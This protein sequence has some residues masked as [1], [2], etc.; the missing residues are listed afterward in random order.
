M[1]ILTYCGQITL[2]KIDENSPKLDLHNITAHTKFL[3]K[4]H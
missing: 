3:V 2:S 1:K 4:I